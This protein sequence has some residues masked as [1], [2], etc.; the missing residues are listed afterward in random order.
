[1]VKQRKFK[2]DAFRSPAGFNIILYY[3]KR[4]FRPLFH[5]AI[6]PSIYRTHRYFIHFHLL[7]LPRITLPVT[8]PFISRSK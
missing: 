5:L 4:G 3:C 1:M 6:Y 2:L 8:I 7:N